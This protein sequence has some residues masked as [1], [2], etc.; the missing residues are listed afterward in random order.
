QRMPNGAFDP[1]ATYYF[2]TADCPAGAPVAPAGPA[3]GAARGLL[4]M[5]GMHDGSPLGVPQNF[6]WRAGPVIHAALPPAG[7]KG[8]LGWGQVYSDVSQPVPP[9][10]LRIQVGGMTIYGLVNG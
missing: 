10:N 7:W 9:Q 3:S 1:S 4:D 6:D 8:L 2:Q 5:I